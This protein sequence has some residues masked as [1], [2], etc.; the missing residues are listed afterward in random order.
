[1]TNIIQEL[2]EFANEVLK[3]LSVQQVSTP[4]GQQVR[5]VI[6]T[7]PTV[8]M[9]VSYQV[10]DSSTPP[11]A[12]VFNYVYGGASENTPLT[13]TPTAITVDK[14]SAWSVTPN[15][16]TGSGLAE[17]WFSSQ[18]LSGKASSSATI[19][20][21]FYHQY[22]ET[23]SYGIVGGGSP[24]APS[25][26][27][28]Q[29]GK[30]VAEKLTLT[31]K[32]AK[33]YWFDAGSPWSVTNPLSSSSKSQQ[34]ITTQPTSGTV[35]SSQ[36]T[37]FSY[38]HQYYLTMSTNFGTV[39]PVSGWEDVG[40]PVSISATAPTPSDPTVEQYLW[41]KWTGSGSGSYTGSGTCATGSC[42]AT[43]NM[44]GPISEAASWTHQYYLTM[45]S[46]STAGGSVSPGSEWLNAGAS[47][48][49]KATPST[50]YVFTS[51]AGAGSGAYSGPKNPATLKVNGAITETGQFAFPVLAV[52]LVSPSNA[53][54][55]PASA[56]SV[57]LKVQVKVSG[58]PVSGA[59][60]TIFVNGTQAGTGTSDSQGYFT[61]SYTLTKHG[62][63]Y[64]WYATATKTN[65]QTGTSTTWT[66]KYK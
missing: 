29:F 10:S 37:V 53:A 43:V 9:T 60:V 52:S 26:T 45:L 54:T 19:V 40:S 59:T 8:G 27:A 58:M 47:V 13:G 5:E 63:T 22:N 24:A 32:G 20:F 34:W 57:V 61:Y 62:D 48:T 1:M 6:V 18:P 28:D 51:W 65:Y 31:A 46:N 44:N 12:P 41:V 15:P 55:I 4:V 21:T 16:L 30:S 35:T 42:T 17:R 14:G 7:P 66:F 2:H 39:S 33:W 36:T 49:I 3:L 11:S 64:I 56:S 25:F 23:V 38:T 50:G